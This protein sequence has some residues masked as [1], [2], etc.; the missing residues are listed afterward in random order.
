MPSLSESPRRCFFVGARRSRISC[1]S[2]DIGA[3]PDTIKPSF[4]VSLP[5]SP[6]KRSLALSLTTPIAETVLVIPPPSASF[7]RCVLVLSLGSMTRL[8]S[9]GFLLANFSRTLLD[10]VSSRALPLL[11]I[12]LPRWPREVPGV[13][14]S[15]SSDGA[16]PYHFSR[17]MSRIS[18]SRLFVF[19]LVFP[20][21]PIWMPPMVPS[22]KPL[23]MS[24][25]APNI[26]PAPSLTD[27]AMAPTL[28]K[29]AFAKSNAPPINF[30]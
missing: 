6:P 17:I 28:R 29:P 4:L 8:S 12:C 22:K 15:S 7:T 26:A 23:S 1:N 27:L 14:S 19:L 30:L 13:V 20:P 25:P 9:D 3:M 2:F 16:M 10:N 5:K 11:N 18:F 21:P 24:L